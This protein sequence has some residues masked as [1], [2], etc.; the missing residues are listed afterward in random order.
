MSKGAILAI[1]ITVGVIVL[2]GIAL[3][4]YFLVLAPATN[5]TG[6][7]K[8]EDQLE[9][10]QVGDFVKVG[11]RQTDASGNVVDSYWLDFSKDVILATE[12]EADATTVQM[13]SLP[14]LEDTDYQVYKGQTWMTQSYGMADWRD[15]GIEPVPKLALYDPMNKKH[16]SDDPQEGLADGQK[17]SDYCSYSLSS[18]Q[19]AGIVLIDVDDDNGFM[20]DA[21]VAT[22]NQTDETTGTSSTKNSPIQVET[23][24]YARASYVYSS[25]KA[26]C[27]SHPWS[28]DSGKN[29]TVTSMNPTT[30][31]DAY[32]FFRKTSDPTL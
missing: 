1:S 25:N 24:Y 23:N 14:L 21:T 22:V 11:I 10:L 12:K 15:Q 6:Q 9:T 16:V 7:N 2:S 31:N 5:Q 17:K 4:V 32:I 20:H 30:L 27:G 29:L 28:L 19:S 13:V 26:S 3:L 8:K 18:D